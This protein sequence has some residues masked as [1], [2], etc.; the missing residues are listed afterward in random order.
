MAPQEDSGF[1]AKAFPAA[2]CVFL[3]IWLMGGFGYAAISP[4]E[5][6]PEGVLAAEVRQLNPTEAGERIDALRTEIAFHDELYFKKSAP[7]ISDFAYD[8]LKRELAA[9]EQA[10]PQAAREG[11]AP[12]GVGDDRA[13]QFPT[14]RHRAR[15]LSLNKSYTEAEL[16]AFDARL[17]R[18]LGRGDLEY[19]VEPKFDGLAISVTYE[20]G[21]LIR[22]VTRGNGGEGDDVTANA[23]TIRTLPRALAKVTPQGAAN[24]T[25]DVVEL[26]GEI[27]VSLAEFARLNRERESA[28]ETLFAQ[29]R[30]LAAGTLKQLDTGEVARRRL[31]IVFYGVGACEPASTRPDSQQALLRQLRAW[32]LPAVEAPR[33]VRG[34][35]AM[36]QAVRALGRERAGFSYPTDGAVVKLDSV[37][38]QEQLGATSQAPLWA[39][40]FKFAPERTET[41]LRTIT[42]QVGRT[43]VLTPVAELVPVHL[44]GTTVAR[45]SL[46]N[47]DEIARRDIRVGDFVYV[48]K[49]GEIIPAIASVNRA[50]RAPGVEPFVFPTVC[51]ICQS[52]LVSTDGEAAVRC[53]NASC[54][55]QVRRRVE[56]FASAAGV[57]IPGLGPALVARLVARGGV[58][59]V[60]DLYRLRRADLLAA[61][62]A[63]GKTT[64]RLLAGIEKSKRAELWRFI[65][66][67]GI[68]QVGAVT[69]RE[70]ARRCGSLEA[71]AQARREDLVPGS[72]PATAK[73][74]EAT[75]QAV[76]AHF[77][78]PANRAVVA[79]LL[80]AG[81][82]PAPPAASVASGQPLTG[83]IF[84]LTGVLPNLTRAQAIEKI[85]AAGGSVAMSL[86]HHTDFVLV[87]EGSGAKFEAARALGVVEIDEEEL[88][89]MLA[90]D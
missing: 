81:V 83:K 54:P 73:L 13:G 11:G 76:L 20:N 88:L 4:T 25:P 3:V 63:K 18:Q 44:G 6:K 17:R 45:A 40:A 10:F 66:G 42:L 51:P 52:P 15:M 89:R 80:A 38:L 43:G 65:H 46:F 8:Q 22:A 28:G 86:G 5:M 39:I 1:N 36:W 69:A 77:A 58:K 79:E 27:Y 87:G 26:R 32:G 50:R 2:R 33:V 90:G 9:L 7:V 34:A 21:R 56:H 85:T 74:G 23:L 62:V 24:L 37:A 68:P 48:E 53:P 82:R 35:D 14:C 57:D 19:V 61:G 55:A 60:A 84:V 75:A 30:N 49:A 59:N 29:P 16:R 78:Q 64:D 67:L 41:Q 47:R 72:G 70:L 31:E 12:A 71:L